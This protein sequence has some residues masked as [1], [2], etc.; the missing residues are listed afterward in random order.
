MT[1]NVISNLRVYFL[2]E[3]MVTQKKSIKIK[4]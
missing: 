4:E 3:K 2:N 1:E